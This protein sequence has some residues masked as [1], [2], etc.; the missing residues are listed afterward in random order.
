[1]EEIKVIELFAGVGGFRIGLERAGGNFF[2]TVWSNQ[3]EPSTKRQHA[4]EVYCRQFGPEGH[5]CKDIALVPTA[6]IPDCDLLCGGFP[7]QDYSVAR[8]LAGSEGLRGKKGVLWWQIERILREK[9][10]HCPSVVFLENVDRLLLSPASQRGRDFAVILQTLADLG[11]AAEWRVINAA[12]YGMPERRRRTYIL[13]YRKG[14]LIY[15]EIN[16]LDEWI[17]SDGVLIKSFP[18]VPASTDAAGASFCLKKKKGDSLADISEDFNRDN[19]L[20]PFGNAGIMYEGRVL[21]YRLSPVYDGAYMTL[22]DILLRGSDRQYITPDYYIGPEDLPKWKYLKGH[23]SELRRSRDGHEF[24]Y[25]EGAMPFPDPLE[26]PARTII[27][28]EGGSS[29][30]RFKHVIL[31]PVTG[32]LRRLTPLELERI[33]MFPDN[34]TLGLSD[35]KRAFLMGNALVCGVITG[36]AEE[37]RNRLVPL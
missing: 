35:T 14:S 1:M 18:A 13:A 26:R 16:N 22:N 11:Y 21:T 20:R 25:C 15:N 24:H 2:R 32:R 6:E 23:K 3:W 37:L 17:L 34:H 27:T 28:S 36:V 5:T 31:D 9:G 10:S 30:S 19:K 4:S 12:D 7:C 33:N 8:T 29:P